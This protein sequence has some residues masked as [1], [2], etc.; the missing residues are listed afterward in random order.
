MCYLCRI[1]GGDDTPHES[2]EIESHDVR[3]DITSV[4]N[5]AA[6]A[7]WAAFGMAGMFALYVI[8]EV[9]AGG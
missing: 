5:I 7:C 2:L 6:G 9:I 3:E 8:L 4:W 1:D